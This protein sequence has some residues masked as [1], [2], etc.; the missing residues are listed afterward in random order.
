MRKLLVL[1][2]FALCAQ[3]GTIW[4]YK[5]TDAYCSS[6]GAVGFSFP[7]HEPISIPKGGVFVLAG[8]ELSTCQTQNPDIYCQHVNMY[9][10]V[11]G[12]LQVNLFLGSWSNPSEWILPDEAYFAVPGTLGME[13]TWTNS[14][15][16]EPWGVDTQTF[17]IVDPP[18]STPEPAAGFLSILGLGTL[19][20]FSASFVP[21]E[22]ESRK[23]P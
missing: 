8:N 19:L 20:L 9:W 7:Q 22:L 2:V 14:F 3:A 15:S 10:R 5:F 12:F 6:C 4:E 1:L 11:D 21:R 18:E 23:L 13:G 16:V 17:S